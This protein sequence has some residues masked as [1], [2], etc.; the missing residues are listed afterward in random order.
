M[1]TAYQHTYGLNTD[2][3][4]KGLGNVCINGTPIGATRPG[5]AASLR[6]IGGA[7]ADIKAAQ[8]PGDL[9]GLRR[10]GTEYELTIV[11]L[12]V[13]LSNL[14]RA[15]DLSGSVTDGKLPLG[16]PQKLSTQSQLSVYGEG[17]QQVTRRWTFHRVVLANPEELL[18]GSDTEF[19]TAPMKFRVCADVTYSDDYAYGVIQDYA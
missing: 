14:R 4:C 11:G 18:L 9:L 8:Y 16:R 7:D 10:G 12:E 5:A 2:N 15:L 17:P 6:V 19:S 1:P 13:T 3:F